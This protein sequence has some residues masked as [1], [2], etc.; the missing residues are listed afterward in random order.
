M[1]NKEEI[2]YLH[3]IFTMLGFK[4]KPSLRTTRENMWSIYI[5]AKQ[6]KKYYDEIGFGV[7]KKRQ[8]ILKSAVNKKLRVNQYC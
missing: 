5:G 2:H 6:L 7:H 1:K 3:E 4:C 8:R